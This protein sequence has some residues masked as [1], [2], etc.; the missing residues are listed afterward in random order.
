MKIKKYKEF[1]DTEIYMY[2]YKT[3]DMREFWKNW[4]LENVY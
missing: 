3:E 2:I 1:Y 4:A